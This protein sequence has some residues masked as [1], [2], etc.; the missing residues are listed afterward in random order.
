MKEVINGDK[1]FEDIHYLI[2]KTELDKMEYERMLKDIEESKLH[3]WTPIVNF[4]ESKRERLGHWLLHDE[5][6][7]HK[8][9][10]W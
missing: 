7:D 1:F 8:C 2:H 9:D 6:L 5:W 4:F 3:I 10:D